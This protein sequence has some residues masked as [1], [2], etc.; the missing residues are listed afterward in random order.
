MGQNTLF[1]YNARQFD[2]K[3]VKSDILTATLLYFYYNER[4]S[5]KK[6]KIMKKLYAGALALT[7]MA[8][9]MACDDSSSS[10]SFE[11]PTYKSDSAL[12]DSCQMEAAKVGDTYYA[13]AENKWVE[14]TDSA[15]IEKLKEGL[16]EEE[17]KAQVEELLASLSS[18]SS[19]KDD[20]KSNDKSSAS[21]DEG[22]EVTDDS[23][24]SEAEEECTGR[25]CNNNSSSSKKSS[26]G[27]DDSG[28]GS[29]SDS[30]SST[31]SSETESS[32]SSEAESSNSGSDTE[33]SNSEESSDSGEESSSS[34]ATYDDV[35]IS[36]SSSLLYGKSTTISVVPSGAVSQC[37]INV[38]NKDYEDQLPASYDCSFEITNNNTGVENITLTFTLDEFKL[39]GEGQ[40]SNGDKTKTIVLY[41][42]GF[43]FGRNAA[44]EFLDNSLTWKG[45]ANST[46]GTIVYGDINEGISASQVVRAIENK[47]FTCETKIS[48]TGKQQTTSAECTKVDSDNRIGYFVNVIISAGGL[49]PK[50]G[51][52]QT[53]VT[54]VGKT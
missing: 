37:V 34:L 21:K 23:S 24:S 51:D 25:H 32:D 41:Y 12:P 16:D 8:G 48:G 1:S 14:V 30:P 52:V 5:P 44:F 10:S 40:I 54:I 33:S 6:E 11:I 46:S 45:A 35:A 31:G 29:D 2:N 26:G 7:A 19:K 53:R 38:D 17:V 36:A 50:L 27:S 39:N 18:N 4:I 9:L 15:T 47:G 28:S 49:K 3:E 13:C 20:S 43:N 42:E 22:S